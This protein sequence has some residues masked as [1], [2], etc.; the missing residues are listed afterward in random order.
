VDT[1]YLDPTTGKKYSY[2]QHKDIDNPGDWHCY[3]M[4]WTSDYIRGYIDG[5]EYFYAPNPNPGKVYQYSWPFDQKFYIKLNLAIGGDW[6]GE[7]AAGFTEAT[8]E[9]DWVRVYQK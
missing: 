2:S 6:G 5:V 1:G 8:Y 4:E 9:I 3:G 7:V